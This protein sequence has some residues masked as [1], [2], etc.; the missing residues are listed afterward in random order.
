MSGRCIVWIALGFLGVVVL[1]VAGGI[2]F[3]FSTDWRPYVERYAA[4][5]LDRRLTI[6]AL[7]IHWG[8]PLRLEIGGVRLA[9]ADWGSKPEIG[10]IEH[11]SAVIDP[12]SILNG[13]LRF[14]KLEITKLVIVLERGKSGRGN[15]RFSA[16]DDDTDS[17]ELNRRKRENF[18]TLIDFTLKDSLITY[19]TYRGHVLRIDLD[20]VIIASPGDDQPVRL[21]ADG[22]Y[23][24]N[25]LKLDAVTQSFQ[26]MRD[27]DKPFGAKFTMATKAD[28][29]KVAKMDF[30]G[31][32]M[33]PLD[34][35]GV[36]GAMALDAR[37]LGEMLKVFGLA[38]KADFPLT[39][40]SRLTHN[41]NDW[42]IAKAKGVLAKDP[43]TGALH[44]VEGHQGGPDDLDFDLTFDRLDLAALVG[45]P[46]KKDD[47]PM[48]T[49]LNPVEKGG[50]NINAQIKAANLV[51]GNR[52]LADVAFDGG[53]TVDLAAPGGRQAVAAMRRCMRSPLLIATPQMVKK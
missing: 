48:A 35:D 19:R 44:I 8:D 31:T 18:P 3:V 7:E 4:E 46:D 45:K 42:K 34:F 20:N 26:A 50:D 10:T 9:N 41:D 23:N 1:C 38:L 37:N 15:W 14:E 16:S 40:D 47:D 11:V 53:A 21:K 29:A 33:A 49:S 52:H 13:P 2:A 24:D 36:D 32:M 28:K 30:D 39:V 22:A 17:S 43:F 25:G 12:R 6:D 27:A 51:Y 5:H